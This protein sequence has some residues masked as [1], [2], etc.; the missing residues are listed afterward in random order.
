MLI[1]SIDISE[2]R[3]VQL[4]GGK[5]KALEFDD[6]E[7]R[8]SFYGRFG[9]VAVV[10]ID[11]AKGCGS[12][13][14]LVKRLCGIADCRV[15]GGIRDEETARS[16][17]ASGAKRIILGTAATP[18]LLK[19]LPKDA[20][21]VALDIRNGRVLTEGW[22]KATD[23][24]LEERIRETEKF[25]SGYLLTAVEKEGRME[26][27][28]W[29]LIEKARNLTELPLTVAGGFSTVEE[30]LKAHDIGCDV[31]LGMALY[32]EK[33]DIV[34]AFVSLTKFAPLAPTITVD[35][36]GQVLMLAYSSK[37]SLKKTLRTG[38]VT[39]YSRSR[40]SLWQK[41]E[42]SGNTQ[43][44]IRALHDCDRDALL[45]V[46][47]QKGIACHRSTYSCFGG[48]RFDL[49]TLHKIFDERVRT[50]HDTS[51]TLK[52]LADCDYLNEK[53]KEEAEE[54][55]EAETKEDVRYEAADLLYF[56]AVKLFSKGLSFGDVLNE[57]RARRR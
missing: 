52:L 22:Q 54:L 30:I 41:G 21:I 25:C 19:R 37:E 4:V 56:I 9:E 11:A 48:R 40:N 5:E 18:E 55:A 45:F 16:L 14:E 43:R 7:E 17:L 47:E 29:E 27:P 31:Q 36:D 23:E 49:N 57:L 35:E 28:D 24:T 20:L 10:D 50:Q 13:R 44:L 8:A 39:Y 2:S 34:E 6:A 51:Y 3:V 1:P 38:E 12:N 26:G 33:I 15:G 32:T 53:L 42:T 46:V